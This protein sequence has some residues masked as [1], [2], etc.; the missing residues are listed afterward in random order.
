MIQSYQIPPT[1][2]YL[3]VKV[4]R[5]LARIGAVALKNS[6]Y[7][8]P[9]SDAAVEDFQWVRREIVDGGGDATVIQAHLIDG[10][11][12]AAVEGLFRAASDEAYAAL[13]TEVRGLGKRVRPK[14]SEERRREILDEVMRFERKLADIAKTDFFGASGREAVGGLLRAAR[15]RVSGEESS[16]SGARKGP[17]YSGCTWVTRSGIGVD[18]IAS[19][20]LIKRFIDSE[21]SFK[22]VPAKGYEPQ[23]GELRFDM[24]DA[25]FSHEGDA[26]TFEVL[27]S[28]LKLKEPG[29]RAVGELVHDIDLKD[30]KFGQPE[31]PGLAAQIIGLTLLHSDDDARLVRGTELFNELLAYFA[32]RKD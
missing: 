19:A 3:R 28:R 29:L 26:C 32:K 23:P 5:R 16:V 9:V 27:C 24:F 17:S 22:F 11:T 18:R 1:P 2:A 14:L 7:V 6:V 21:A 20:W 12:D 25:E 4:G 15:Q 8:L 30:G 13:E 10:L 31:T